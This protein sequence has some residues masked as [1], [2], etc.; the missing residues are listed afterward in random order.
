MCHQ[1]PWHV[2]DGQP[3]A[4]QAAAGRPTA[5]PAAGQQRSNRDMRQWGDDVRRSGAGRPATALEVD[6]VARQVKQPTLRP[7]TQPELGLLKCLP[8][9]MA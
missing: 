7:V 4:R 6:L 3:V 2:A 9:E 1:L 5:L 8:L